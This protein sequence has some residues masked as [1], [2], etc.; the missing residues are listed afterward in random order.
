MLGRNSVL[1][2]AM[3][4]SKAALL[5][6]LVC[7]QPVG[8]TIYHE[9]SFLRLPGAFHKMELACMNHLPKCGVSISTKSFATGES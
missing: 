5:T 8:A 3:E 6:L 1:M 2:L 9:A 7:I 4:Q